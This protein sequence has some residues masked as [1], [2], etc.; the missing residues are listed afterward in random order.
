MHYFFS[1]LAFAAT[2]S[3]TFLDGR[4]PVITTVLVLVQMGV[5][6]DNLNVDS[7]EDPQD[8]AFSTDGLIVFSTNFSQRKQRTR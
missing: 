1:S 5:Y 4:I 2:L 3:V 6:N 8:V 7:T